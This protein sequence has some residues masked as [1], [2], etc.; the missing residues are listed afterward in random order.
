MPQRL[1]AWAPAGKLF[2]PCTILYALT[3]F[4][5][6]AA[7][8]VTENSEAVTIHVGSGANVSYLVFVEPSLNPKPVIYAWHYDG[9]TNSAGTPRTGEDLFNAVAAGTAGTSW[10]LAY[11]TGAAGLT[12]S[13]TIGSATSRT[14]NPLESPVWTYWIQGG[15]EYVQWGDN[16]SFTF[17]VGNSLIISPSYWDT[18]YISNGSYDVWTISSFSYSG[19][20]SDTHYYTDTTGKIQPVTFGTYEG[21]P[22]VLR[23]APAVVSCRALPGGELEMVFSVVEGAKYQLQTQTGLTPGD[24]QDAGDLF[25]ANSTQATFTA[26]MNHSSG[27][28]FYRLLRKE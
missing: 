21:P 17:W 6:I 9:M 23:K 3:C 5:V 13:F 1:Q 2:P 10:A 18:R 11:N 25:A 16:E 20:T 7:P 27:K 8:M 15:S 19:A 12:T 4:R 26:L 14:I 28:S 24:W 22:P